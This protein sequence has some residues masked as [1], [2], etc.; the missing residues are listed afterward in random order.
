[1]AKTRIEIESDDP[2]ILGVTVDGAMY[3]AETFGWSE[4]EPAWSVKAYDE[5]GTLLMQSEHPEQPLESKK[6]G[7]QDEV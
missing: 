6:R 4:K 7:E 5:V 2:T 1:M 3:L